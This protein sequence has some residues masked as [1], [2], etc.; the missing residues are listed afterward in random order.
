L[1]FPELAQW[2]ED[3]DQ[4]PDR[5]RWGDNFSH[6]TARFEIERFMT[7]L[8]LEGITAEYLAA[9]TGISDDSAKRLARF[10]MEDIQEIRANIP[11]PPKRARYD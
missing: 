9:M 6:F 11:R 8:H 10:A 7:L 3:V 5:N 4:D 1:V 2:L